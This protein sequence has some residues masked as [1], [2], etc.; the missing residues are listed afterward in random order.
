MVK[1]NHYLHRFCSTI[2]Y[3]LHKSFITICYFQ[4]LFQKAILN[5]HT[6]NHYTP[7]ITPPLPALYHFKFSFSLLFSHSLGK[8]QNRTLTSIFI[9]NPS[10]NFMDRQ[11]QEAVQFFNEFME[12]ERPQTGGT[13][14]STAAVSS[15]Q[16]ETTTVPT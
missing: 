13:S 14:S 10:S 12:Q 2:Y 16:M 15:S 1:V 7:T 3:L 5:L 9:L 8:T 11:E 4:R 6:F